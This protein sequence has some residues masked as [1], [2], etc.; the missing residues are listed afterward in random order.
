MGSAHDEQRVVLVVSPFVVFLL[1]QQER[2]TIHPQNSPKQWYYYVI[3]SFDTPFV[4]CHLFTPR[5]GRCC[6]YLY[7]C[8]LDQLK[9]N[10]AFI[11]VILCWAG[12]ASL[13]IGHFAK[14][15]GI[16]RIR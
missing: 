6:G 4:A 8:G 11:L 10:A 16:L 15:M 9:A 12:V 7:G 3:S 2:R 14:F 5:C 1:A 13:L